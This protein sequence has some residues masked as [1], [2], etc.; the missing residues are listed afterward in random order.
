MTETVVLVFANPRVALSEIGEWLRPIGKVVSDGRVVTLERSGRRVHIVSVADPETDAIF[1]DWPSS[2]IPTGATA[3]FS[4]DYR[5]ADLA[6]SAVCALASKAE[7]IVDN[8][9]G[10]VASG[11]DL[12]LDAL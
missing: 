6:Y 5:D 8:N 1:E 10:V 9:Y 2:L 4:L 11:A 3:A 12:D 7:V